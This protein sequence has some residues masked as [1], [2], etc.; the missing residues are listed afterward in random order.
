[1]LKIAF[2]DN[3]TCRHLDGLDTAKPVTLPHDAMLAEARTPD[4]PGGTNT[5]WFEGHDYCYEKTFQAPAE[6]AEKNVLLEFEGVYHNAE[7]WLNGEQAAFHPYG[8]TGFRVSLDGKLRYGEENQ[9]RVIARNA[10]QPNSRWYSGAG[11]YRPVWLHVLP[12]AHI[13]P[14]GVRVSTRSIDPPQVQVQ[15]LTQ[16]EAPLSVQ[17]LD[18]ERLLTTVELPGTT[19]TASVTLRGG[20][21]WSPE[22]PKLY[23]CRATFGEDVQET[24]FGIR[25]VECDSRRGFCINGEQVILRGACIHHDNGLLGAAAHPQAEER[26]IRLLL[27]NG[28]N[29]IRSAHNPC[30][31]AMLDACDRLGMLVMDEYVDMW[32]IHKTQYDYASCMEQQW[33]Q[34]LTDIVEKDFNHPSVVMYSIGNEVSETAQPR[35]IELTGQ[36][37]DLLHELDSRPVTCGINIFFNYLSSMGFG[38]YSD[39]K[40]KKEAEKAEKNQGKPGKKKAV[41]SEFFNNLA[42][43]MGS[44]FMKFGATLHGSNVKTREAFAKLDVAGYNYGINRYEGDFKRY[45]DRVIVG[46]ET[47]CADAA[48]FWDLAKEHPALIGDFVWAGMDYL[49]ELGIGAWEYADY[50]PEF[51]HGVGWLTAGSGRLDI[52]G[53][54]S[55]EAA[56][57]QVAFELSPIRIGVVPADHAFDRHSPSAWRMS[58][59]FESWSWNGAEGKETQVEVYSRGAEV[60][61][62]LNGQELG[63]KKRAK[64]CRTPFRVTYQPG[65]LT[66]VAYDENGAELYRTSLHSAGDETLLT[67][68]PETETVS[69]DGLCYVRLKYTDEEGEVKPLVRGDV[70]VTVQGGT[71]LGLG[72]ACPY[73]ERGYLT[74]T[75]DTYY[76]EALA[77]VKPDGAG[78]VTVRGES[79]FGSAEAVVTCRG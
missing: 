30:S 55:G 16:G 74:D 5:G 66:A 68:S 69:S 57:T 46:S 53:K 49:G 73:N 44:G 76:G 58:N 51:D 70:H 41:G 48:R 72:S 19:R 79:P 78:T 3:W 18:G 1:M 8:Y 40:A 12:L 26:K 43:L 20:Q 23:T 2:N 10:D 62:L 36:M 35:G 75:T 60:A 67:L 28:Y 9:V 65:E 56:Y 17:L 32:Y 59:T 71:L 64:N 11:I 34:D 4:S 39:D 13:C 29:A 33:R 22:H 61:L 52:T 37:R 38:V 47:F 21:L 15:V 54:P 27:E 45:P 25:T 6:W 63:R 31:R 14:D 77:I 24:A 7:V 50:A 42:G